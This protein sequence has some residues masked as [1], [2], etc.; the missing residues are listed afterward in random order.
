MIK[1]F[2][3]YNLEWKNIE[4]SL[5]V[6]QLMELLEFTYSKDKFKELHDEI[7]EKEEDYNPDEYYEQ[8]KWRLEELELLDDFI[9]NFEEYQIKQQE[10][11]PFHWRNRNKRMDDLMKGWD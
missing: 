7:N 10:S 3:N 1:K 5:D 9:E 2:E 8:I 11:D 6:Y 4:S